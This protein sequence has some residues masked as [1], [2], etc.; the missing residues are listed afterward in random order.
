MLPR[1]YYSLRKRGVFLQEMLSPIMEQLILIKKRVGSLI[2]TKDGYVEEYI[3]VPDKLESYLGSSMVLFAARIYGPI[4]DRIV[5]LAEVMQFISLA[6]LAHHNV[7]EDSDSHLVSCNE[8]HCQYPVLIGDY[9][10]G[11]FFTTLCNAGLIEH[12]KGISEIICGV[13]EK[14]VVYLK[15][16]GIDFSSERQK[17]LRADYAE[18]YGGC[19]KLGGIEAG[20]DSFQQQYLWDF[21][22]A[23]GMALG[24]TESICEQKQRFFKRASFNLEKL[25]P[26]K[27]RDELEKLVMFLM[28]NGMGSKR[29]VG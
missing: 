26:G 16:Q 24:I 17:P 6:M 10:Y 19:C 4:T 15:N 13:N 1:I 25:T 28:N 20:A 14:S 29:M 12:L 22:H 5:H 23:L 7:N 8:S 2:N 27:S 18:F 3:K 21:G 9:L 11:R